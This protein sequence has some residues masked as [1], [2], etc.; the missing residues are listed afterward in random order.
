MLRSLTRVVCCMLLGA[1][2]SSQTAGPVS[3]TPVSGHIETSTGAGV[4]NL[5]RSVETVGVSDRI[6]APP[7]SVF[8]ALLAVYHDLNIPASRTDQGGR[9]VANDLFKARRKLGGA[10]MQGYV[11][12]GGSAGQPNAETF[13]M[14]LGI[15]STVTAAPNG[16]A[17]VTSTLTASGHDP[18][19]GRDRQMRCVSTG[20][21]ERRIAAM[22][23]TKL[24][25][26]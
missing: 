7:D 2:A 6:I 17:L 25:L 10:P 23:R 18:M 16:G 3:V 19:F 5:A 24:G 14:E 4:V 11:D 8:Q 21:F 22:V 1:C 20:E 9:V 15:V 12:C 13:D 26:K